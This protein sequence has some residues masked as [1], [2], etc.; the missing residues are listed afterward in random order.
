MQR[1]PL[2]APNSRLIILKERSVLNGW[3]TEGVLE[4]EDL[5]MGGVGRFRA[6]RRRVWEHVHLRSFMQTSRSDILLTFSHYLPLN[7]P[8]TIPSVVGVANLAPFS[9]YARA[10]E[11]PLMRLKLTSLRR[12][13]IRSA[14]RATTV[15]ALSETCRDILTEHGVPISKIVVIPN[16]V[17]DNWSKPSHAEGVLAEYGIGE[18][19]LLYVSHFFR[20]KNHA[21]LIRAF[22]A[23][24]CAVRASHQ[25]VLVGGPYD[26]A[27]FD[28]MVRLG[29]KLGLRSGIVFVAG[30]Q[31]DR[32]RQLYQRAKLFIFPSLVENS[33]NSLLE[34]MAAGVPVIAGN[35]E[36]MREFCGA[37]ARY[38]DVLDESGLSMLIAR[39][40]DD[41][42]ALNEMSSLS[43]ERAQ[44]YSWD[45]FV[46]D[47]VSTCRQTLEAHSTK[48]L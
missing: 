18:S 17:D 19:Y 36:P 31:G 32:L 22:A 2:H 41:A 10:A 48:R 39:L 46:S 23:L 4:V 6:V 16:G 29:E 43:R 33:P 47:V 5:A 12:S 35:I 7:F 9:A 13:I 38:F 11:R 21:T 8:H 45:A 40:V 15:V 28:D 27:Y 37:A 34:A 1:F 30:E 25:L 44:T 42:V 14:K 24:P 3:R 26:K 20:Y